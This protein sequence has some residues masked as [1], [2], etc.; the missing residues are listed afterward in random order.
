MVTKLRTVENER[1]DH[2]DLD[3]L[4]PLVDSYILGGL[5]SIAAGSSGGGVGAGF[6]LD[7]VTGGLSACKVTLSPL[8]FDAAGRILV[9]HPEFIVNLTAQQGVDGAILW[10]KVSDTQLAGEAED[11]VIIAGGAETVVE[12]DVRYTDQLETTLTGGTTPAGDGWAKI[13]TMDTW[14]GASF[15]YLPHMLFSIPADDHGPDEMQL[16]TLRDFMDKVLTAIRTLTWGGHA[17]FD[18]QQWNDLTGLRSLAELDAVLSDIEG[19]Y[20]PKSGGTMTGD[21]NMISAADIICS[22]GGISVA[23]VEKGSST[24]FVAVHDPADLEEGAQFTEITIA[25]YDAGIT[26]DM[27]ANGFDITDVNTADGVDLDGT[28]PRLNALENIIP[29]A[30]GRFEWTGGGGGYTKVHHVNMPS[31]SSVLVG[32]ET[33]TCQIRIGGLSAPYLDGFESEVTDFVWPGSGTISCL[34]YTSPS[35]RDS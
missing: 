28:V 2:P 34:L 29:I 24:T 26:H 20:L 12:T 1:L 15:T 16:D 19:D 31:H 8:W 23:A 35:P 4:V 10:G 32:P 30:M 3:A 17:S 21:I 25:E 14:E 22:G 9:D 27:D 11:R 13:V 5:S 18:D 7:Q 6:L 33:G